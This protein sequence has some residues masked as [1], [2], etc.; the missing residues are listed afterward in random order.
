MLS[1]QRPVIPGQCWVG[2]KD[3]SGGSQETGEGLERQ[4]VG[5]D[6]AMLN[7]GQ[8]DEMFSAGCQGRSVANSAHRPAEVGTMDVFG[9]FHDASC[10]G[11][12][13]PHVGVPGG[14]GKREVEVFEA[15]VIKS[16]RVRGKFKMGRLKAVSKVG[17]AM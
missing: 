3:D 13:R 14:K 2:D 9:D 16:L 5:Q 6:V 17:S 15:G 4:K 7:H 12:V 10:C 1:Q 8:G 11:L